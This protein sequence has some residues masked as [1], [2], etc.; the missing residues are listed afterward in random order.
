M[1][2]CPY[3]DFNSHELRGSL[4][5]DTY[6]A[7]L[8]DDLNFELTRTAASI[9]TVYFGGGTPSLFSPDSFKRI[10][11]H[12]ALQHVGEVT[13]EANPGTLECKPFD[14]YREAG[15]NRV[16]IGVQSLNSR[17]LR[18]L[19]RIHSA[20]EARLAVERAQAAGFDS[21]NVDMM[22][23]LPDQSLDEALHD[24]EGL[25]ALG[26]EH[27][28]W[29]QLTIEPNT[30]FSK[31]PPRLASDDVRADMWE[32]G[33]ETLDRSGFRQYEVSAFAA[34]QGQFECRHNLN[35]WRFG[36]YLG[37]GA[38]A[39][40]KV[41]LASGTIVRTQKTRR[42]ED[43]MRN[44]RTRERKITDDELPVEFMMNALRLNQG[45]AFDRF[46]CTTGLLEETLEPTLTELRQDRLIDER[47]LALTALGRIH[48][49]TVVERFL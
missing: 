20:N 28:S 6:V 37:I 35:Y 19:G 18:A 47:R 39:H 12:P 9:D 49:N 46:A 31:R 41:T 4:D 21:V 25:I 11:S 34:K 27:I 5:E 15:I 17:A 14:V 1:R 3:C 13:M 29:Y 43:Y 22:F 10:L 24:L 45:V 23:G 32:A 48:L 36:D 40:G 7:C 8:L 33:L 42:P 44:Q 38:G 30:E 2:K 26:T 16:S